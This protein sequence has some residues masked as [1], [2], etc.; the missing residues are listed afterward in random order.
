MSC[1]GFYI[2]II[3]G[4]PESL[5]KDP[6]D[7]GLSDFLTVAHELSCHPLAVSASEFLVAPA[8]AFQLLVDLLGRVETGGR[9]SP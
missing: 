1:R 4:L 8:V 7:S 5:I 3:G 2:E 9:A 6:C